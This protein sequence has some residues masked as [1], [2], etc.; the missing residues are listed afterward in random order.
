MSGAIPLLPYTPSR[1]G[2]EKL[3]FYFY[4]K[5][6]PVAQSCVPY[7]DGIHFY[8]GKTYACTQSIGRS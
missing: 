4:K 1:H 8:Q 5:M 3:Y 2:E 6:D 7:S